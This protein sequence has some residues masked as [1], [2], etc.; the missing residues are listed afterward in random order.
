MA[1]QTDVELAREGLTA[2]Q[3]GNRPGW[4][5]EATD[6]LAELVRRL[7]AREVAERTKPTAAECA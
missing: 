4:R 2:V 1:L 6:A 7:E 3:R 5:S